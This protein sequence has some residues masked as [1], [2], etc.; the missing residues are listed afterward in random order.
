[1]NLNEIIMVDALFITLFILIYIM[2]TSIRLVLMKRMLID[3]RP[4]SVL[5]SGFY[6]DEIFVKSSLK[7]L[8]LFS[9]CISPG[10]S[11][12][13][14][15]SKGITY[16]KEGHRLCFP[17]KAVTVG[18]LMIE[19]EMSFMYDSFSYDTSVWSTKGCI[20]GLCGKYEDCNM[21]IG[22]AD[23]VKN[24]NTIYRKYCK[25]MDVRIIDV[26]CLYQKG[27]WLWTKEIY[28]RDKYTIYKL[29]TRIPIITNTYN[30]E[31]LPV[32]TEDPMLVLV[33][34]SKD[35]LCSYMSPLDVPQKNQLGDIQMVDSTYSHNWD[36]EC[37]FSDMSS[38]GSCNKP[39]SFIKNKINT[40]CNELPAEVGQFRYEVIKGSLVSFPINGW[41]ARV[42][43]SI[44]DINTVC[45]DMEAKIIGNEG[46]NDDSI[47]IRILGHSDAINSINISC[48]PEMVEVACD[49]EWHIYP[50][51]SLNDCFI[52]GE[53]IKDVR[54]R[55]RLSEMEQSDDQNHPR[56]STY[57]IITIVLTVILILLT[58]K[59]I[60]KLLC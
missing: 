12:L 57:I 56:M 39:E 26:F 41:P 31:Y 4:F 2:I 22:N 24:N 8:I 47:A 46:L 43:D 42:K 15:N 52:N 35:Y 1:M 37:N 21:N 54:L 10:Y 28:L 16:L 53:R 25:I 58:I 51:P 38:D 11:C 6:K 27:C 60:V 44:S 29:G 23:K 48:Y 5:F 49:N 45:H 7:K 19:H 30:T 55:I 14:P 9:I 13:S 59:L 3:D 33:K 18:Q 32:E 20:Y 50:L 17:D 40:F 34:G 36:W